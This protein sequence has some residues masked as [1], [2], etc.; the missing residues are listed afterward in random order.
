MKVGQHIGSLDFLFPHEYTDTLK[1]FQ[2]NAPESS[3]KDI[4]Y[5]IES[6]TRQPMGELFQ[7]FERKPVGSASL[8]QVSQ[9]RI[10]F[11]CFY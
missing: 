8:A 6:D 9:G 11:L 5:V 4:V 3:L 1:C 7:S 2:Y 10:I